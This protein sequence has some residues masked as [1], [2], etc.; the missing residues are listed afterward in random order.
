MFSLRNKETDIGGSC[1]D[2][3]EQFSQGEGSRMGQ[4][5]LTVFAKLRPVSEPF[6][7]C[8][9]KSHQERSLQC[10]NT[11]KGHSIKVPV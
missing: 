11:S 5:C 6:K 8:D 3:I 9:D 2:R 7:I 1:R 4:I 10:H